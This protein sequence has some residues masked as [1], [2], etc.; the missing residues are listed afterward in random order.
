MLGCVTNSSSADVQRSRGTTGGGE[1]EYH[2]TLPPSRPITGGYQPTQRGTLAGGETSVTRAE[3]WS[4]RP[5]IPRAVPGQPSAPAAQLR[6]PALWV[7]GG[8]SLE[9][10][11][12]R[13]VWGTL[14]DAGKSVLG[15]HKTY[16]STSVEAR[17]KGTQGASCL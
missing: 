1:L 13:E 4:P 8:G 15:L 16:Y 3:E 10:L 11:T 14:W 2:P 6:N 17:D 12:V 7:N 9:H 5:N